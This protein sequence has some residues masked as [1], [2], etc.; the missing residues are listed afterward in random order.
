MNKLVPV[1]AALLLAGCGELRWAKSDGDTSSLAQDESS[2]RAAARESVQRRYGPP[3]P[4]YTRSDP[5]FGADT[6]T[7]SDADRLMLEAQAVDRCMRGRGYALVP[8]GK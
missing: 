4:T 2:C 3:V 5:R 8:A 6:T 1:L 7:P